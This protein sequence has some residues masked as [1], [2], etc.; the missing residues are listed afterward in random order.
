MRAQPGP[1]DGQKAARPLDH[2][3]PHLAERIPDQRDARGRI[4]LGDLANPFGT[5]TGFSVTA[6]GG[7]YILDVEAA[8]TDDSTGQAGASSN[9]SEWMPKDLPQATFSEAVKAILD[10][11]DGTATA[12]DLA[13]TLWA[14][15][16]DKR[17]HQT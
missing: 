4:A 10:W 3:P 7:N 16:R 13:I 1:A 12:A 15:F 6:A 9:P 11:E 8:M 17:R 14:I 2:H 5:R